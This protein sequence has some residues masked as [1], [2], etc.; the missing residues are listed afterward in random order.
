MV[1]AIPSASSMTSWSPVSLSD[2]FIRRCAFAAGRL[3]T[4]TGRSALLLRGGLLGLGRLHG[5][6]LDD[7]LDL[8][9]LGVRG[10][11]EDG[12]ESDGLDG[13]VVL[14]AVVVLDVVGG[15]HA[16]LSSSSG[17]TSLRGRGSTTS[18]EPRRQAVWLRRSE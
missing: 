16:D 1:A 7:R 12:L 5:L 13:V 15:A 4:D 11:V 10:V 14:L 8:E 3:R 6:V 2:S 17:G 9:P 18:A